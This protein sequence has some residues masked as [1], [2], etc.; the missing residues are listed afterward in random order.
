LSALEIR[1]AQL[2]DAPEMARLSAQLGYP[3]SAEEMAQ[4]VGKLLAG[5]QHFI[6]VAPGERESL[7]GWIHAE[8]RFSLEGEC[9]EIMGLVVD[10]KARRG[11]TGRALVDAAERWAAERGLREVAVRSNVVRELSH[12]FYVA[13]G[14]TRKK[15]QHVYRKAVQTG[16]K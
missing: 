12:P 3:M 4:L 9:T 10:T 7:L 16:A 15:T 13:L 14:F 5:S 2:D 6:A 1:S 11:G 8:H